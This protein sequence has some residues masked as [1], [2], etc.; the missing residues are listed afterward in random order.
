MSCRMA[1][2]SVITVFRKSDVQNPGWTHTFFRGLL[3]MYMHLIGLILS[4]PFCIGSNPDRGHTFFHE[5]L[6][7][8]RHVNDIL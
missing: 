8:L 3:D 6:C 2:Q 4:S 5:G 7:V 1:E